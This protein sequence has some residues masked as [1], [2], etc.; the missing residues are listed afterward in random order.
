MTAPA[1][2]GDPFAGAEAFEAALARG[3]AGGA[4]DLA[5]AA[6]AADPA[7]PAPRRAAIRAL[8]AGGAETPT[9]DTT[10][11]TPSDPAA[12]VALIRALLVQAPCPAQPA[13]LPHAAAARLTGG[14]APGA[15][16]LAAAIQ[17]EAMA[18]LARGEATAETVAAVLVLRAYLADA[19]A[20]ALMADWFGRFAA[21][22]LE[23]LFN[24]MFHAAHFGANRDDAL[25]IFAPG[26]RLSA[27]G[28]ALRARHLLLLDWLTP[29]GLLTGAD[30]GALRARIEAALAAPIDPAIPDQAA[31]RAADL[32]AARS[33]LARHAP[34][35]ADISWA[36]PALGDAA[37]AL[38]CDQAALR[39]ALPRPGAGAGLLH[40]KGWQALQ[41]LRITAGLPSP[42]LLAR[43]PRVAICVSG[44]LRGHETAF[45]TWKNGFL[46]GAEI[47]IFVHAWSRIG[48]AGAQ[49]FR[50]ILPFA[51]ARFTAVWREIAGRE[52][53]EAM[54]A[55]QPALFAALEDGA[56]A[57]DAAIRA[58]TG[59][60][61]VRLEDDAAPAFAGWS[62]QRKMHE[63]IAAAHALAQAAADEDGAPW[64]LI[65]RIRPDLAIRTPAFDWA[66]AAAHCAA[67]AEILTEAPF[68]VHY[69]K[70]MIGDQFAMGA[71]AAMD[72][73][74]GTARTWG[75]L[76]GAG[77]AQVPEDFRGHVSLAQTCWLAG[78]AARR[79]P[80]RFGGLLDPAPVSAAAVL[81]AL[82]RD[83]DGRMDAVDRALLHAAR[84]DR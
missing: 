11:D 19:D 5:G 51:G 62:N 15:A 49:P 59:A 79:A 69:G 55:R 83:A 75:A 45:A 78:I 50:A 43:R 71:P 81:A 53:F 60:R 77:L 36:A 56:V 63:K 14:D 41:A 17:A 26:G 8:L 23:A 61:A 31:E 28:E 35:G 3:D 29:G 39:A 80:V 4:L 40:A 66:E 6:I 27:A 54:Q 13:I 73:Y 57:D 25:A 47:G 64:D 74:A 1:D 33:L 7:D 34:A 42:R 10:P 48:R 76:H 68:G 67:R 44:Q 16:R 22:D 46:K 30:A 65:V 18:L 70:P 82:E 32:E 2:P 52:G 72:V 20:P 84:A 38:T 37:V 12:R 24:V 9:P 21:V 58:A